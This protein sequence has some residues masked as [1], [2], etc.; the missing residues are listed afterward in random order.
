MEYKD[1]HHT[2]TIVHMVI[3]G[4]YAGHIVIS[5]RIKSHAKEAVAALKSALDLQCLFT[6]A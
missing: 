4:V 3:D 2:G 5:D 1:C 6:L